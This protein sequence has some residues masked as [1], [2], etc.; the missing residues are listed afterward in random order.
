MP[1]GLENV[2]GAAVNDAGRDRIVDLAE[3][4]A[5]VAEGEDVMNAAAET[6]NS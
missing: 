1:F 5:R 4:V 3:L 2:E 6:C